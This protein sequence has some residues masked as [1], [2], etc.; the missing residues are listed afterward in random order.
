MNTIELNW[1]LLCIGIIFKPIV[2]STEIRQH[3]TIEGILTI[4]FNIWL[5]HIHWS[6]LLNLNYVFYNHAEI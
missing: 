5:L 3:G 4:D 1:I 2:G 6:Y